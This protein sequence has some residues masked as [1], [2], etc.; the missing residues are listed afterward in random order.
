ML[1]RLEQLQLFLLLAGQQ[2]SILG[3][4]VF[5]KLLQRSHHRLEAV[6]VAN[7]ASDPLGQLIDVA[8]RLAET[9]IDEQNGAPIGFVSD[10][11]P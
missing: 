1:L 8:R 7:G 6:V 5:G 10:A 3:H 2:S 11:A 4:K 9:V